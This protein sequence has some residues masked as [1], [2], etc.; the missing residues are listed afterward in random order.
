MAVVSTIFWVLGFILSVVIAPQLRIWTWGPTMLCFAIAAASAIPPIWKEGRNRADLSIVILGAILVFWLTTR[1]LVSPVLELAESDVLL[2]AMAVATF[3]SFRAAA[4]HK[5]C[6]RILLIGIGIIASASVFVIARQVITP[7]YSPVFPSNGNSWPAGFFGHYSYGASFLIGVS[8]ILGGVALHSKERYWVKIILG[9]IAL[10]A[11]VAIYY[12]RSRGAIFGVA[13]GVLALLFFT[14]IVG[15]RDGRKWFAYGIVALPIVLIAVGFTLFLGWKDA[16]ELRGTGGA[17]VIGMFDNG[18]RLHLL[19]IA[20]S[21]IQLHP[22][23]GGG[24]RSFSWECFRF[25]DYD[26][27]GQ[28]SNKPEHVHNEIVQTVTDYG[29]VGVSALI[30]F[31]IVLVVI[32][33]FRLSTAKR[34]S[35]V[36]FEDGWRIGGLAAFAGLFIQSNFEGIFRI[37][38]GA[39]LLALSLSAICLNQNK[40]YVDEGKPWL[41]SGILTLFA[42]GSVFFL[43]V[44]GWKG[45]R[46]SMVLWPS[47]F[48]NVT[49]GK[50][51]KIDAVSDALQIWP[52][53]S[54]YQH[55]GILYQQLA[56]SDQD[57]KT[58][59]AFLR[60]SLDDFKTAS[61]LHP[62]DPTSVVG[63][64]LSLSGLQ[65]NTE[66]EAWFGRAIG[67]Q[68]EMEAGFQAHFFFAKHLNKKGIAQYDPDEPANSLVALELASRNIEEAF[69][70]SWEIWK[71]PE[72]HR[73]R[74]SIFENFARVLEDT[75]DYRRALEQYDYASTLQHGTTSHYRAGILLGKLAVKAWEERRGSNA[76]RLFLDA[77]YRIGLATELPDDVT[78]EKR[79]EWKGY[80]EKSIGYLKSAKYEPSESI[81]F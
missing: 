62:F 4:P 18:I 20:A 43:I 72:N 6:R 63:A 61:E 10:A 27:M 40:R 81:E 36:E 48:G 73:L 17:T 30:V 69:K 16:Q 57:E 47:F 51:S 34:K 38:P 11:L 53:F 74:V 24:A 45:T 77:K 12:T 26:A 46:V 78:P 79:D 1:A 52:M 66:A 3:L 41:K 50:E 21:C 68:G 56:A 7:D 71:I 2:I 44:G 70:F 65:Q 29:I 54:L 15:K 58:A 14:L 23:I 19:G 22:W 35:F 5:V 55:R 64:A 59:K 49:V 37:P 60:L 31:L 9:V 28:G 80:L 67:L 76:L 32:A 13:G 39:I 8:L 33:T 75:G 25:W 42:M